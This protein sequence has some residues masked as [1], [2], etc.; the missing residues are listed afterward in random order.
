MTNS[1]SS[2]EAG[3][4]E[5]ALALIASEDP[6]VILLDLNMPSRTRHRSYR[7]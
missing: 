1:T 4:G 6:A 2:S 3:D 5:A 7:L